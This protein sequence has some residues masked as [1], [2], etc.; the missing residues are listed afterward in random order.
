MMTVE[1]SMADVFKTVGEQWG[2]TDIHIITG[3]ASRFDGP[4]QYLMD[5]FAP[6]KGGNIRT[7]WLTP[8]GLTEDEDFPD[9]VELLTRVKISQQRAVVVLGY[10]DFYRRTVCASWKAGIPPG[11]VWMSVGWH[12]AGWWDIDYDDVK[13]LEPA[14]VPSLI[15]TYYAGGFG[16]SGLG[17]PA[18][19]ELDN[20]HE[21]LSGYTARFLRDKLEEHF[22]SGYPEGENILIGSPYYGI[23]ANGMDGMCV[24]AYL[25]KHMF[26]QGYTLSD[27]QKPN[28]T[29]YAEMIRYIKGDDTSKPHVDFFGASG[30]VKFDGNNLPGLL[31]V[32]QA[33]FKTGSLMNVLVATI[34]PGEAMV[35]E[36]GAAFIFGNGDSAPGSLFTACDPGSE[37]NSDGECVDCIAG[38]YHDC[39]FANGQCTG[40]KACTKC[41]KAF[42]SNVVKAA[43]LESCKGCSTGKYND[44]LGALECTNCTKG[45][46]ANNIALT[47]CSDCLP[48]EFAQYSGFSECLRCP[49]GTYSDSAKA[50][51]C[52]M[53]ATGKE[54]FGAGAR[55]QDE[56]ICP[57]GEYMAT[58]GD[59]KSCPERMTCPEG[60]SEASLLSVASTGVGTK[61]TS[62]FDVAYPLVEAG[63]WSAKEDP[64][65][66]FRCTSE[67]RCIGGPPE[68]CSQNLENQACAHCIE[69]FYFDGTEC[70]PCSEP[71][72][73]K[74]IFPVL[75]ALIA[76]I[77]VLILYKTSGDVHRLWN[78][79]KNQLIAI[80][81]LTLNHQQ[82]L[83]IINAVNVELSFNVSAYFSFWSFTENVLSMFKVECTGYGDFTSSMVVK[84]LGPIYFAVVTFVT[85][86]LS[87]VVAIVFQKPILSMNTD[88][89][90]N[91]LFSLI[92]TFFVGVASL[93][94]T[95]FKCIKSPN[96]TFTM[97]Q[98]PSVNCYEG[99]WNSLLVV[100]IFSVMVYCIGCG[101]LFTW[102]IIVA[103][104]KFADR[105]FQMRWK[106]LFIKFRPDCHWWALIIMGRGL[107]TNIG[108]VF[109]T[110]GIGQLYWILA[111]ECTYMFVTIVYMPWRFRSANGLAIFACVSVMFAAAV[112]ALWV[113]QETQ[114]YSDVAIIIITITSLPVFG[115]LCMVA[116]VIYSRRIFQDIT[117]EKVRK[118]EAAVEFE[119]VSKAAKRVA[120]LNNDVGLSLYYSAAEW[121]QYYL[122]M[123]AE[124]VPSVFYAQ[125][126]TKQRLIAS[127][128][129]LESYS[130][131]GFSFT[132]EDLH[133]YEGEVKMTSSENSTTKKANSS[134]S[135]APPG[136]GGVGIEIST[137]TH[138]AEDDHWHPPSEPPTFTLLSPRGLISTPRGDSRGATPAGT[139][140]QSPRSPRDSPR[141]PRNDDV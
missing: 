68:A 5:F 50:T 9:L 90:I 23:M 55:S 46:F 26:D 117:G 48:G 64:F 57:E 78:S 119:K 66:L 37:L 1:T 65:S 11:V 75:P 25:V 98:D 103:P 58:N 86:R 70:S 10:E 116:W 121:D 87:R 114:I 109:L 39:N 115:A 45:R 77:I 134:V 67:E 128:N 136:A 133:K 3:A 7:T 108:F 141:S 105:V 8:R 2:W 100:G 81:F 52:K 92:L 126:R 69:E 47:A 33:Q 44:N 138:F 120:N 140:M 71:E 38:T 21:C 14:C 16:V 130:D 118:A 32:T 73:S 88:R 15:A 29:V 59:C 94:L 36:Q 43:D 76:F 112:N 101:S 113:E 95:L 127:G 74:F 131:L 24:W 107:T 30:R 79:W 132:L 51:G 22:V 35:Y 18:D 34:K 84:S 99:T 42:A 17:K 80:G 139:P 60:S 19:S 20:A 83:S 104:T 137:Q 106:F 41:P 122:S 56:C 62:G 110:L 40:T 13:N 97:K 85:V 124:V 72:R 53:C 91:L 28:P 129:I 54:T 4:A 135:S 63:Y 111:C 6:D 27:L 102:Q 49:K 93:S 61:D 31:G 123:F 82:L 12:K 125:R 96:G 89:S